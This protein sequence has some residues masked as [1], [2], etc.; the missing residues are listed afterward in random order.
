MQIVEVKNAQLA[1]DFLEV[2]AMMNA[3]NAN[4]I[5][6]LNNEVNEVFDPA[7]NKNFNWGKAKRW[8]A[9][10]DNGEPVGRIAAFTNDKYINKG[11]EFKT[12]GVGF[13]DCIDDQATA[14][15]LFDTAKEW[16]IAE[17][18]EAMDGPINFGDRDKWW[19]LMVEGFEQDL[20][21]RD[22][23]TDRKSTR[24]NSSHRL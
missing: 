11:T 16:L 22:W 14:N 23:E 24:L 5:R 8:V 7:K 12:G 15:V 10:A 6:A 9:F 2:N 20:I 4:Y 21:Y 17:G 19:G 13:F 18:M 3:G 1:W